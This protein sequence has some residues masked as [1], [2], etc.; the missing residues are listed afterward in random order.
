MTYFSKESISFFEELAG[1][2]HKE[3]F[4]A[5]RSR[6]ETYIKNPIRTLTQAVIDRV[7][8]VEPWFDLE[9][10]NAVFRINRDIRFAKDKTPYKTH[11]AASINH[12]GRKAFDRPGLYIHFWLDWVWLWSGC[13]K[14]DKQQLSRIRRMLVDQQPAIDKILHNPQF[15]A[16]FGEMKGEKNKII[17]KEFKPYLEQQPLVAHKQFYFMAEYPSS[18]MVRDDIVDRIMEHWHAATPWNKLLESVLIEE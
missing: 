5:N 18:M 14:P 10:K 11:V 3:R 12:G 16:L 7:A 4:H 6:Y 2:N 8:E 13:Y 15:L 17:P 1:N 9:P